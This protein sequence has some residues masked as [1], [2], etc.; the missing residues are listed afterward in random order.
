MAGLEDDCRNCI[1]QFA[2]DP[3][4]Q[5]RTLRGRDTAGPTHDDAGPRCRMSEIDPSLTF[6]PDNSEVSELIAAHDWFSSPLGAISDWPSVIRTTVAMILRSPLPIVTLWGEE[7]VMI[8]NDAYSLFAGARHPR[9]LGSKVRE[10]WPEVAAFNDHVVDAVY[11]RGETLS[12]KDQELTLHRGDVPAP[13]WMNLDYSPI[14]ADDGSRL[15]VIAIVV[16]TTERVTADRQLRD[17]RARLQQ[18]YDQSPLLIALLSGPEHRLVLVNSACQRLIGPREVLGRTVAEALPDLVSPEHLDL[19]DRIYSSGE[20]MR[21]E[22][23]S[24][25][26]QQRP[27]GPVERRYFDFLY[28]P[29]TDVHRRVT[30]IFVNGVDVTDRLAAQ[31]ATRQREAQFRTLAQAMPHHVWTASRDGAPD[32]FNEQMNDYT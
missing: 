19:L 13:A 12:F 18:M 22:A 10:G 21:R 20:V 4:S 32:W 26:L 27:D 2:P 1:Y 16:E 8:Y 25:H 15:G 7:G 3:T 5:T 28:Q 31:E 17:E 6:L 9:L 29:L 14:L 30:G 24:Y 11:H 23:V